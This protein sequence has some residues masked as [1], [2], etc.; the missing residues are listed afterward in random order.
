[1]QSRSDAIRSILA[2]HGD[3][4]IYVAST[5]YIARA[6][7]E[8]APRR[9]HVFF[10]QG[11][12]G[13]APAI[14]LGIALHTARPV[15]VISGDAALLMHLG[16]TH[17]IRD[18]KPANLFV[19]VLDNGCHESVGGQP[20]AA[21]EPAYPGVYRILKVERG[22]RPPRVAVSFEENCREVRAT[23]ARPYEPAAPLARRG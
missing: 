17:T 6:V 14:G 18:R 19:Y 23:L 13:L 8:L 21:L 20:S 10:M 2:E 7:G 1:M 5:G 22:G 11:S 15:V 4:A 9:D 12:M 3:E 16:I